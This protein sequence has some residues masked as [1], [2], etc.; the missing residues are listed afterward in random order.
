[1]E[2]RDGMELIIQRKRM[3]L[4]VQSHCCCFVVV[5]SDLQLGVAIRVVR[6]HL[7]SPNEIILL[8]TTNE[9]T[10]EPT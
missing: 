5:I 9:R 4:Q 3:S 7:L 10:N 1:M 8:V 6:F 2:L